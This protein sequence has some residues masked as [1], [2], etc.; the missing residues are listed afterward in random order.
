MS[1]TW[2]NSADVLSVGAPISKP[3]GSWPTA[4]PRT[5]RFLT[6]QKRKHVYLPRGADV[7][8]Q[9]VLP[10][11]E[12]L[13]VLWQTAHQPRPVLVHV[14]GLGGVFIGRV[15]E[16]GLQGAD[17]LAGGFSHVVRIL[18]KGDIVGGQSGRGCEA[19]RCRL[20]EGRNR[21]FGRPEKRAQC[22][23][24]VFL[25]FFGCFVCFCF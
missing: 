10:H 13:D 20:V 17:G 9:L 7:D 25:S 3:E 21:R 12:L 6:Y 11:R 19:A 1:L 14:V 4:R 5:A 23:A 24:T 8:G 2:V 16:R 15:D 22:N 18:G